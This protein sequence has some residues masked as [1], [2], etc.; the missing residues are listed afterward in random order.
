MTTPVKASPRAP[1]TRRHAESKD[2]AT[3]AALRAEVESY[4][5]GIARICDV[6]RHAAAGNLE[7]RVLGIAADG[8][9][10]ELAASV[11]HLLDLSDAFVREASASLQHASERKYYRRVLTRGLLG[12]YRDAA[13]LINRATD[14]MQRGTAEL[15]RAAEARLRL[16]DE[17][18]AAVKAVVDEVAAAATE[19]R[20]TALRLNGTAERT[21]TQSVLVAD[22]A[23]QASRGV[24]S[25]AAAA[26][27]ITA[28]VGEIER[29]AL[30]TRQISNEAVA[31]ATATNETVQG[32]TQASTR[33]SHVVKMINDISSQTRLLALNATIE[34]VR[35]GEVG[36]GFAVVANEVKELSAKTTDATRE[37]EEQ[38][39]AI[40]MVSEH[41][42]DSIGGIQSTIRRVYDLSSS[43]SDAVR[44]QR[45]ANNEINRSIHEAAV[46]TRQ[47]TDGIQT[48]S[49]AVR[50][51]SDAAGRM[52]GAA[53]SLS[54]MSD[55]LR[56][57][58][59]KFLRTIRAGQ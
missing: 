41:A 35:A 57:E 37:I 2:A 22:S 9:L 34:A 15:T 27:E 50:E 20:T 3:I 25:V 28:T 23:S 43:V 38:A 12:T 51:T 31:A 5:V 33:I 39:A 29:Q 21:S 6:A 49:T 24:D 32:L 18:E 10:G 59:E 1:S 45:S 17:F 56:S 11:N 14:Q 42:V 48:V 4:R 46:G 52:L 44:E 8:P 40:Q 58:V 16:A 7:P 54:T 19:S 47:V 53:D 30:E 26:E 55:R 13:V 36:R